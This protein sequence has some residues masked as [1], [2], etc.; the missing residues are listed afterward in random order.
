MPSNKKARAR[1]SRQKKI[2]RKEALKT[3]YWMSLAT[4]SIPSIQI[5]CNHGCIIP[6]D[7]QSTAL[8]D[9]VVAFINSIFADDLNEAMPEFCEKS[10]VS[11]TEVWEDSDLKS[12][13]MN[14]L[15]RM[16]V[17]QILLNRRGVKCPNISVSDTFLLFVCDLSRGRTFGRHL[18]RA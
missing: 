2:A 16:G 6:S 10:F 8:Q 4:P 1:L 12:V 18:R 15:I 14:I 13:V 3:S 11:F 5:G 17:N 9:S 7:H